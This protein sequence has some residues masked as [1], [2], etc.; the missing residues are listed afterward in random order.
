M[1]AHANQLDMMVLVLKVLTVLLINIAIWESVLTLRALVILASVELN[2]EEQ[3]LAS[4]TILHRSTDSVVN[5]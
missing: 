3:L 2:V 1:M 5:I 4:T